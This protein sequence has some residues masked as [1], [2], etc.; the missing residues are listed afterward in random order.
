MATSSLQLLKAS[1]PDFRNSA[2]A[3]AFALHTAFFERE[4]KFI[5]INDQVDEKKELPLSPPGWNSSTDSY[6]FYYIPKG[7]TDQVIFKLL[8]LEG[9]LIASATKKGQSTAYTVT[10]NVDDFVNKEFD[11][12]EYDKIYKDLP[13]L[14]ALFDQQILRHVLGEKAPSSAAAASTEDRDATRIEGILRD[15]PLRVGPPRRPYM[16]HPGLEDDDEGPVFYP[17]QPGS[18]R[19][20]DFDSD[21]YPPLPG[22]GGVGGPGGLG[23]NLMGP[24]NFP[25]AARGVRPRFDPFGPVPGHGRPNPD[26]FPPP[27]FPPGPGRGG[28]FGFM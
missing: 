15:D 14:L 3:V 8:R 18:P 26:H 7:S 9:S 22:F 17:P 21:L 16:P 2:D 25:G 28:G 20:G 1:R 27:G 4:C 19:G 10:I 11:P 24:R 6:T 23:G 13:G 12:Q 5:G